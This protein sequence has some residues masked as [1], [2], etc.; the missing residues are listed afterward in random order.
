MTGITGLDQGG[1]FDVILI[2]FHKAFDVVPHDILIH[3]LSLLGIDSSALA[4]IAAFLFQRLQYVQIGQAKSA[5]ESVSSGVV[6]GSMLG[7][8]LFALYINDLPLAVA[9]LDCVIKFFADDIKVY[10]RIKN[11]TDRAILQNALN[12]LC[13]WAS[14]WKL[15]FFM[16]K[17][18]YFQVGYH[19]FVLIY[20][21]NSY[22]LSPSNKYIG[23]G[24]EC[25]IRFKAW[26]PLC[27]HCYQG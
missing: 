25:D 5:D 15:D 26:C 16:E 17:F 14:N 6:Q 19:N 4:W 7:S 22:Q 27:I 1:I 21:L 23:F 20:T 24:V 18:I 9:V 11:P 12:L 3:K 8:I 2:D 10:K 13:E